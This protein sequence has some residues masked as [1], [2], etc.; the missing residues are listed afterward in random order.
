MTTTTLPCFSPPSERNWLMETFQYTIDARQR[1]ILFWDTMRRRGDIAMEQQRLG[2]PPVL[3]YDYELIID[4]RSLA[5]PVNYMLLKIKPNT[6]EIADARMRPYIVVDPRA[7]HGPG[8]GGFKQDS[9]MGFALRAGHPVYF[10]SFLPR[11]MPGQTLEDIRVAEAGFIEE[12]ARRHSDA[13]KPCVIA[14]CQAGWAIAMLASVRPE[15][16]GPVI[17]SGSPLAYWSGA[18]GKNPMRY[19]GG[20]L[21]GKWMESLACDIGNGLFDGAYLV[22]NFENLNPANSLWSK[23]YS[24]YSAV[25]SEAERFLDFET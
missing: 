13:D 6:A 21:G 1:G 10:V 17:L 15:I 16:M 3:K 25:D 19:S 14:N 8:I 18:S 4:G 22:Q 20:L 23:F 2:H 12:V 11:P 24:L 7:G 5:R 9:E